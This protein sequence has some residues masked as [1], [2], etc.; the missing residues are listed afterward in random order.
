MSGAIGD[1]RDSSTT[2]VE[3][4]E[5]QQSDNQFALVSFAS[6]VQTQ[7]NLDHDYVNNITSDIGNLSA[8]GW[9]NTEDAIEQAN[10]LPWSDQS[11]VPVN[12]K[13]MQAVVFFSDGNPTAFRDDFTYRDVVYDGVAAGEGNI[14]GRMYSPDYQS[15]HLGDHYDTD[16]TGDGKDKDDSICGPA[17]GHKVKWHIFA[18]DVYG[19]DSF[20]SD[21]WDRP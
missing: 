21:F 9:T 2:F 12:E 17:T 10:A 13:T 11:G 4:F 16:E 20:G 6:G 3:N 15:S 14:S 5:D 1:L 19:L 7:F 18:D 8:F